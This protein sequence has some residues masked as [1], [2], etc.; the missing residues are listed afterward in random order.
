MPEG[1]FP[2]TQGLLHVHGLLES[3][4]FEGQLDAYLQETPGPA[5]RGVLQPP[6]PGRARGTGI[7]HSL[8]RDA[9]NPSDHT[10]LDWGA[11]N[12]SLVLSHLG[13]SELFLQLSQTCLGAFSLR[14]GEGNKGMNERK[15]ERTNPRGFWSPSGI[16]KLSLDNNFHIPRGSSVLKVAPASCW[17]RG[18]TGETSSRGCCELWVWWTPRAAEPPKPPAWCFPGGHDHLLNSLPSTPL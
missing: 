10:Q 2:P 13:I 15:D 14:K 4:S 7:R 3:R 18:V 9:F 16:P 17:C 6:F 5:A 12:P 11:F 8:D 1:S